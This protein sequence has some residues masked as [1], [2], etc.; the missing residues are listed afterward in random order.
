MWF[1]K[2]LFTN[3]P[4]ICSS[5]KS[6]PPEQVIMTGTGLASSG[7]VTVDGVTVDKN[8][9]V[10]LSNIAVAPDEV[11][12][13]T[14]K[15]GSSS[16][17]A[18]YSLEQ[19]R[20]DIQEFTQRV[21]EQNQRLAE[22]CAYAERFSA[23]LKSTPTPTKEQSMKFEQR[24][25]L[26]GNNIEHMDDQEIDAVLVFEEQAIE[27]LKARKFQTKRVQAMI[28]QREEQLAEVIKFL[29]DRFDAKQTKE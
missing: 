17:I 3:D 8:C 22:A 27:E 15:P 11:G 26:N 7:T 23:Q 1:Y 28:K 12:M 20:K 16:Y 29:D 2:H 9:H 21:K 10:S 19:Q 24:Y 14:L 18:D 4:T 5:Y 13:V 6:L 25:Y